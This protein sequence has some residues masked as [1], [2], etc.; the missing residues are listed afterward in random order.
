MK[1]VYCGE[2]EAVVPDRDSLSLRKRICLKCHAALL[3]NDLRYILFVEKSRK[4][5]EAKQKKKE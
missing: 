5:M 3:K 1:C 4:E 2:N